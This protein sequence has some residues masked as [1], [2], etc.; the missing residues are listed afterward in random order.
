MTGRADADESPL[1]DLIRRSVIGEDHV[2]ETPYGPRR[3]T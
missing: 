1:L 3:V 2:M